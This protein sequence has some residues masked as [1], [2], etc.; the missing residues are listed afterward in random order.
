VTSPSPELSPAEARYAATFDRVFPLYSDGRY[1]EALAAL[2]TVPSE[3]GAWSSDVTHIRAC[4]LSLLGRPDD[5]LATLR[6]G[7]DRGEWWNERILVEDDDLAAVRELPGFDPL[8]R[9][10]DARARAYNASAPAE[11]PLVQRP[12]DAA[13]GVV[14]VLHGSGQR[15]A[16][17]A[18]QWSAAVDAGFVLVAVA[19]SQRSTPTHTSWP[20]QGLAARDIAHALQG[21]TTEE[22]A[23]PTVAAGF[24]AGGR[25]ALLWALSS[26]PGPV[27]HVLVVAPSMTP[28][29]LPAELPPRLPGLVLLGEHD[30]LSGPVLEMRDALEPL[31]VRLEVVTGQHHDLPEDFATRLSAELSRVTPAAGPAA[32]ATRPS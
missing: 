12:R 26:E 31:G 23:L 9:E 8:C 14:V 32:P 30:G 4:L 13:R 19:S 16:P 7:L 11:P 3:L 24:S 25:A 29:H 28:D 6:D 22:R 10:A 1:D 20:D 15:P 21:L 17:T 27:D 18:Q 5:A 2:D